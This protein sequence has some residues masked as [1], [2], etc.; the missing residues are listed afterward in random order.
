MRYA[1]PSD[2]MSTNEDRRRG[3]TGRNVDRELEWRSM[4]NKKL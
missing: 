3:F 2:I 1:G 4:R